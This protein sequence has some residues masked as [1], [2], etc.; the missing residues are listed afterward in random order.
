GRRD[1]HLTCGFSTIRT[2]DALH[3][4]PRSP[5]FRDRRLAW[6]FRPKRILSLVSCKI[7]MQRFRVARRAAHRFG[8]N[9]IAKYREVDLLIG[10]ITGRRAPWIKGLLGAGTASGFHF[11]SALNSNQN[12]ATKVGPHQREV[13]PSGFVIRL[14]WPPGVAWRSPVKTKQFSLDRFV[15]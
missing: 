2:R 10:A 7:W 13:R 12:F 9:A 8:S 14:I 4:E 3:R 5:T 1:L 15:S 11:A 6:I